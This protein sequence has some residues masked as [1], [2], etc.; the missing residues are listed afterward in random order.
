MRS[1]ARGFAK[2]YVDETYKA[3][4]NLYASAFSPLQVVYAYTWSS[5]GQHTLR[6]VNAGTAGHSRVD[7]DAFVRLVTP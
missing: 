2:V 5:E 3:T 1:P 6:I 4:I 7:V